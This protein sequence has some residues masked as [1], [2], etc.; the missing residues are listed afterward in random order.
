M[1]DARAGKSK[2]LAEID[3]NA[4]G[5]TKSVPLEGGLSLK[6]VSKKVESEKSRK[7]HALRFCLRCLC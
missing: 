3:L 4:L 1:K 2:V 6:C 5:N 7:F